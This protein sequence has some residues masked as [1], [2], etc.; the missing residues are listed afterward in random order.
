MRRFPRHPA[1]AA[2]LPGCF[3]VAAVPFSLEKSLKSAAD[4]LF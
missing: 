2:F 1:A 3:Q 4:T